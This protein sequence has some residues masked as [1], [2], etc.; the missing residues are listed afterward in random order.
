MNYVVTDVEIITNGG[1]GTARF[2]LNWV[3]SPGGTEGFRSELWFVPNNGLTTE[4]QFPNGIVVLSGSTLDGTF[5]NGSS[6]SVRG[7][8]TPN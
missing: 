1:G 2:G 5:V 4:F 8:L 3:V 6:A 7:Y